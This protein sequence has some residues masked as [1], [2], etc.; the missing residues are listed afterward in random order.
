MR[1]LLR[2]IGVFTFLSVIGSFWLRGTL[3]LMVHSAIGLL[4]IFGWFVTL[5]AGTPAFVLLW[6]PTD[7]GRFAAAITWSS[8]GLY[9]A[10]SVAIFHGPGTNYILA[11]GYVAVCGVI[12][13]LVLSTSARQASRP[14]SSSAETI[15]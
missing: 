4:T 13:T 6:R 12:V 15:A 10:I 1:I 9:Y 14:K 11:F 7:L 2:C 5:V 8:I 3:P